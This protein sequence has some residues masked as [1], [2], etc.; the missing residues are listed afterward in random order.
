[1]IYQLENSK[2]ICFFH[3]NVPCSAHLMTQMRRALYKFAAAL[4]GAFPN[5]MGT[6]VHCKTGDE[7]FDID[8]YK[9]PVSRTMAI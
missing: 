8:M 9:G 7:P 4:Q 3:Y 6:A 1:M 5:R 2:F